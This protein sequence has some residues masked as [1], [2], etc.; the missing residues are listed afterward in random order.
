MHGQYYLIVT[1]SYSKWP[2]VFKT[3]TITAHFTIAK[4]RETFARFGL[5]QTVVSDA[6]TQFTSAACREFLAR[7]GVNFIVIAPGHSAS[8]GAAENA[9]RSFKKGLQ[10]ALAAAKMRDLSTD[11]DHI[12]Q[13]YL[14][15]YRNA[16]RETVEDYVW[17]GRPNTIRTIEATDCRRA[18]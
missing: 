13:R 17:A 10:A 9:V 12:M 3:K 16:I 5:P 4:L 2:E 1:D 18:H 8:N 6:G 7:N 15:G 14:F 11:V